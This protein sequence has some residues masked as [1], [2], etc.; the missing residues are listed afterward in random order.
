MVPTPQFS[1]IDVL[2]GLHKD[3]NY[4]ETCTIAD[5]LAYE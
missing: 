1:V 5:H 4:W 2:G 3:S